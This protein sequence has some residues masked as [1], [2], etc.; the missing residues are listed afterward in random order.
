[1][2][3]GQIEHLLTK[4]Y[5]G[6]TTLEEER[7]LQEYFTSQSEIPD[8]LN[9]SRQQFLITKAAAESKSDPASLTLRI[10]KQIDNQSAFLQVSTRSRLLYRLMTAAS[11][12]FLI[13]F[14]SVLIYHNQRTKARDTFS[15]PELAYTEAQKTLYY[16][17]AKMNKG[18][19]PLSSVAKINT[20]TEKLR[21]LEKMDESMGMLNLVS[22]INK[23]SNLKK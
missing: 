15:D 23:S 5:K 21:N 18:I 14:A 22:F 13:G 10:E 3:L 11:I 2:E 12:V 8:E 9:A 16:I 4:Y 17:S 19:R 20:A 1:M 6:D 7:L